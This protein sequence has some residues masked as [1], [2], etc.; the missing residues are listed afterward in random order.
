MTKESSLH[1]SMTEQYYR[2]ECTRLLLQNGACAKAVDEESKTALN[3]ANIRGHN[4]ASELL[5]V[6]ETADS[7]FDDAV[8]RGE[9]PLEYT[10]DKESMEKDWLG[11][12]SCVFVTT[13]KTC[14]R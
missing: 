6:A 8:E 7:L 11:A 10:P 3:H 14:A 13:S 4:A 9:N 1:A 5:I 2:Q 12:D